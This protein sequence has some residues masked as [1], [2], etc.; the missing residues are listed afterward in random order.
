MSTAVRSLTALA[1]A[2]ALVLGLSLSTASPAQASP[3]CSDAYQVKGTVYIYG[4]QSTPVA[5][6][7][8]FYSPSCGQNWG[9]LWVW[10]WALDAGYWLRGELAVYV[11]NE[12]LQ[13]TV[14]LGRY[15]EFYTDAVPGYGKCT[16]AY[17]SASIYGPNSSTSV[18]EVTAWGC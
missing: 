7:K 16:R 12:T 1:A 8:Q 3:M 18:E 6:L 2:M 17:L 13:G 14:P 5:S 10:Q 11:Q 4:D 15:Q 9:Y